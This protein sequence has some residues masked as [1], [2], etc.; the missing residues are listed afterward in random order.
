MRIAKAMARS[1][2]CSRREAERWIEEGRVSV[3]GEVL[4]SPARDVSARDRILIDGEPLPS[5]E[6]PRLWRYH[7]PK[8]LVTTHRDPEGRPTVFDALPKH[9]P[10][11]ISIGR[12]DVN[13]EGLLLLTNDGE[14]ARYLELPATGWLRRYRVRAHG[15]ITQ[16]ALDGLKQGVEV[17]GVR[18]GPIEAS[19]DTTQGSNVW[20]TVGLR[21][22]KHREV[23]TVLDSLGL[24]VNRLIRVSFGP[25]QLLELGQG[26][27][28][29]VPRRVLIDQLGPVTA[30]E[31]GL[32]A[33]EAPPPRQGKHQGRPGARPEQK[34]RDGKPDRW[35]Q[36]RL[37]KKQDRA[38]E[39][40][41]GQ[42]RP[43]RGLPK[44]GEGRPRP[45]RPTQGQE[46]KQGRFKP[47]RRGGGPRGE[48]PSGDRPSGGR[49]SGDRK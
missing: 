28:E 35:A 46:P 16:A 13:T 14:L 12:L 8:G 38:R 29:N 32:D 6:P 34:T 36:E 7:K 30:K 10:R 39:K 23:R 42:G 1:G 47:S 17:G 25:F 4:T 45:G 20:L 33:E 11:V 18:Y 5:P 31:L 22:G 37:E 27:V 41:R 3:N 43:E 48:R 49:P 24:V 21:E 19:L 26:E 9:M 40:Q 2:L 15:V 44:Q